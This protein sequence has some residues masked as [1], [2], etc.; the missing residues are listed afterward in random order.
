MTK[1]GQTGLTEPTATF[2]RN[3][4]LKRGDFRLASWNL[5]GGLQSGHAWD[6]VREDLDRRSI[7]VAYLQEM[8]RPDGPRRQLQGGDLIC[9]EE[10]SKTPKTLRYGLGFYVVKELLD[11]L[12]GTV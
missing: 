7:A 11:N 6:L 5:Q 4:L 8:H 2:S 1:N 9:L 3:N 10:D 12:V